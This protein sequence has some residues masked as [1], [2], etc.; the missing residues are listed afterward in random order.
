MFEQKDPSYRELCEEKNYG[1]YT[2]MAK[3]AEAAR[4]QQ[5]LSSTLDSFRQW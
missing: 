3:Q 2:D 1:L 5:S 4:K